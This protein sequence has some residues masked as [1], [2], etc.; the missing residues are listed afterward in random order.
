MRIETIGHLKCRIIDRLSEDTNPKFVVVLCHGYGASGSDLVPIGDELLD[1]FPRLSGSVQ[2]VFPEAPLTLDHLGLPGGRAWWPI[3]IVKLQLAVATGR[4]REMRNDRPDGLLP[5][6]QSLQETISVLCERTGLELSR[7]IVGGFSQ[8]AM[9]ST[10]TAMQLD[11][12]LAALVVM[13]GTLLNEPEWRERA[14]RHSG[15]RVLQSHGTDDPLLPFEAAEELRDLLTKA[16]AS[17]EFIPFP[18]GHQI[19]F[20]VFERFG[21]LLQTLADEADGSGS[22]TSRGED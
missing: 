9:L 10:E 20:E 19:P 4:F 18:G 11:R 5:A 7:M 6:R 17:V 1:L 3:D 12:N 14:P 15:L 2:F 22:S 16:G 13:S 8:G 21:E